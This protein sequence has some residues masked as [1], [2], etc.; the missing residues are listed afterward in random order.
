MVSVDTRE[1]R[2]DFSS[3][4]MARIS[5]AVTTKVA[6]EGA[7]LVEMESLDCGVAKS[8]SLRAVAAS[9]GAEEGERGRRVWGSSN[10]NS[11]K[12]LGIEDNQGSM[13]TG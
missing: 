11:N 13:A 12:W 6:S 2:D 4:D 5:V 1:A 9:D 8:S 7:A 3:L 10:Q